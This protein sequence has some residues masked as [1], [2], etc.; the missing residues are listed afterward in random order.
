[1]LKS[2]SVDML[3]GP[4]VK[5]IMQI[6][7]PLMVMNI[8]QTLFNAADVAIV[9]IFVGDNA[10]AAVGSNGPLINLINGLFIGVSVGANIL[11][12][13]FIGSGESERVE[14]VVGTSILLALISGILVMGITLIFA[15]SFLILMSCDPAVLELSTK[16]LRIYFLGAPFMLVYNYSAQILR[17]K[18]DAVR[19][20]IYLIIAGVLNVILNVIFVAIFGLG[21]SG[22]AIATVV[23]QA[24]SAVLAF[25]RLL[26]EKSVIRFKWKRFRFYKKEIKD[27]LLIGIPT[28]IQGCMFSLANVFIQSTVNSMGKDAMAGV[29]ISTQFDAILYYVIYSPA[30]AAMSFVSQNY[31]AKNLQRIKEVMKKASLIIIALGVIVGGLIMLLN[32]PLFSLMTDSEN[33]MWYAKQRIIVLCST[34]Y[35]CG[36]MEVFIYSLRAI[37]KS[38]RSMIISIIFA[39][40]YRIFWV[41]LIFP[42]CAEM[43]FLYFAWPTSW[44]LSIIVGAIVFTKEFRK[45]KKKVQLDSEKESALKTAI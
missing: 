43:Y 20:M 3:N 24:V 37:N 41:K 27:L 34:Y 40:V 32:K 39:C 42:L 23:S 28:G 4:I 7:I 35:L 1:M 12:A 13:R 14:K 26:F 2:K 10:V 9:G 44:I 30:V 22:V 18:G 6:A 25:I 11:I 38:I 5:G 36:I 21:V 8:L 16:Y 33:V 17:A 15:R 45:F 31:G 19:P 29:S